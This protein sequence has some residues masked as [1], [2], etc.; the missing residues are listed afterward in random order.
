MA[1]AL[2]ELAARAYKEAILYLVEAN[3][4][5]RRFYEREGFQPDGGR[6][7]DRTRPYPLPELRYR[8]SL[9]SMELLPAEDPA[10]AA[11]SSSNL[12]LGFH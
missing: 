9:A 2:S 5:A 7:I 10:S 11:A 8:R 1:R 12:A 3:S 6:Q 4:R